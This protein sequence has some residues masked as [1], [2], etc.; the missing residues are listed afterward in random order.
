MK[1][2]LLTLLLLL[3]V[4]QTKA[5]INVQAEYFG[6]SHY[7]DENNNKLGESKGSAAVYQVNA[8]IPISMKINK[9][10]LAVVWG[11][12]VSGSYTSLNNKDFTQ[13]RVLSDIVNAQFSL[14]NIAPLNKK[15]SMLTFA[16]AGIYTDQTKI[17]K[18]GARSVLGNAG[19]IFIK[20]I[21]SKLDLGGGIAFNNAFGYPMLFPAIYVSYN[22]PGKYNFNVSLLSG[23]QLSAGYEISKNMTLSLIGEVNGQLA[24]TK[25]EGKDVIFTH[26]YIVTGLRPE[27]KITK[28]ISLPVTLGISAARPAYF[29]ERSLKNIFNNNNNYQFQLSPYASAQVNYKF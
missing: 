28:N 29:T 10:S 4:T 8:K 12:A 26:Q 23:F 5:Q 3:A 18:M 9:D 7:T 17:S 1:T 19:T 13:D 11:I 20:K 24:L 16:G 2:G 22:S 15:W 27:F 6:E 14:F 25:K 21:N